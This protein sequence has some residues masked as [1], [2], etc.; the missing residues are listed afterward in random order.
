[1][2]APKATKP[3]PT[4]RQEAIGMSD[5]SLPRKKH[6]G[7]ESASPSVLESYVNRGDDTIT[8]APVDVEGYG[9]ATHWISIDADHVV[10][11]KEEA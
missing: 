9:I 4:A 6:T 10:D 7:R 1:M 2:P 3:V 8:M 11:L 5:S